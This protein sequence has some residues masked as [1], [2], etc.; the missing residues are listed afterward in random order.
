MAG[1]NGVTG[2]ETASVGSSSNAAAKLAGMKAAISV[3]GE[4]SLSAARWIG[5]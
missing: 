4:S 3:P 1:T 5:N 2:T